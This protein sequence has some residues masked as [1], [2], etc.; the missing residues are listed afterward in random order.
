V[1]GHARPGCVAAHS[2]FQRRLLSIPARTAKRALANSARLGD[3]SLNLGEAAFAPH[4]RTSVSGR[5]SKDHGGGPERE[6][7]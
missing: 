3:T 4:G 5:V 6:A 7:V 1:R 2:A